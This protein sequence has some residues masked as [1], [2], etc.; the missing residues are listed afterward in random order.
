MSQRSDA[1][2]G[3]VQVN[4]FDVT[5]TGVVQDT[6][7]V[8]CQKEVVNPGRCDNE[9]VSGVRVEAARQKAGFHG[10]SLINKDDMDRKLMPSLG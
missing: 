1:K 4:G 9:S 2:S 7:V 8:R 10:D 6:P 5:G 3:G